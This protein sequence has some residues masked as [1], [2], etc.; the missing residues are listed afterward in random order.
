MCTNDSTVMCQNELFQ[1][2]SDELLTFASTACIMF[3]VIGVPGNLLTIF[4]LLYGKQTRNSTAI[5]II[6]L[7]TSD[8]LFDCFNLPLAASTFLSRSWNHSDILCR[9][10]PL[11]RYGLLAVSLF[12]VS[13]I[14]I[15]RYIII[16]HPRKYPRIYQRRNLGFMIAGTWITSFTFMIP[17]WRGV[18]GKFGL[19]TE[20]GSCSI[21]HDEYDRSPKEFLFV[22]AFMV[23]CLCIVLCYARIF[24]LVRKA[25]VRIK[26][27]ASKSISFRNEETKS[28]PKLL[29]INDYEKD[30]SDQM[31]LQPIT[32]GAI[33]QLNFIDDDIEYIDVCNSSENMPISY[34]NNAASKSNTNSTKNSI[35]SNLKAKDKS[36][37]INKPELTTNHTK[38]PLRTSITKFNTK[39]SHYI[40]VGNNSNASAIYPGR[41]SQKDRR[42][43]KMI[44]IIF[45]S[46]IICYLP[47][48]ITKIWKSVNNIHIVNISG[49]ILIY[50]TTCINPIIYVLISSEYRQAYLNLIK[51]QKDHNHRKQAKDAKRKGKTVQ[52]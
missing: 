52:Y 41:M 2:Y 26:D 17:T 48:T 25:A 33:T 38:I 24:Y 11:L 16:A 6:N 7:S 30:Q 4:A 13:L 8:L 22:I 18:W 21:L 20:I 49:Y 31:K 23:P 43:L 44:L 46:F 1:G 15:N 28:P 10:F 40:S 14:T 12:T 39:K 5:F 47:I 37:L 3:M 29:E 51:C 45:V 42:L 19:D 27:P 34:N 9:L 35:Q 36:P 32:E 50:M